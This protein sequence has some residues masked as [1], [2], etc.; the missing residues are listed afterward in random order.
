[1][2]ARVNRW[3]SL[4]PEA[5]E[6]FRTQTVPS[7]KHLPGIRELFLLFDEDTGRAISI[8]LWESREAMLASEPTAQQ[9]RDQDLQTGLAS[10]APLV[11]RYEVVVRE[12]AP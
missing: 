9:M 11:E 5:I 2:F 3:P 6:D 7:A 4:K 8:S 10:E 1:M 12:S